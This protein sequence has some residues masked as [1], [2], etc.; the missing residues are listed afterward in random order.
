MTFNSST[1]GL[2]TQVNETFWEGKGRMCG[3]DVR[4]FEADTT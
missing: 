4:S 1:K 2:V 3:E